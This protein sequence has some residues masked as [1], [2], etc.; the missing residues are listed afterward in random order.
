MNLAPIIPISRPDPF[1]DPRYLYELKY[2][3]FRGIADTVSGRILSKNQNWMKKFES[4]L[5][6]LPAGFVFD[7]E[8]VALD[9]RGRP[10]FND[11]LFGRRYRPTFLLMFWLLTARMCEDCR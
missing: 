6:N 7:G 4:L 10:M 3:G 2:D 8:I 9:E 11:L 1:D 5:Q